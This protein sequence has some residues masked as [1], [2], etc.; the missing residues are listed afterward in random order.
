MAPES[1]GR[2]GRSPEMLG[3]MSS[4]ERKLREQTSITYYPFKDTFK[5]SKLIQYPVG[6]KITYMN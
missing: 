4:F 6:L 1:S 3:E 5:N 2:C